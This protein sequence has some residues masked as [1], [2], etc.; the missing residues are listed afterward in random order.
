MTVDEGKEVLA[1]NDIA[2]DEQREHN[3]HRLLEAHYA[4]TGE[5]TEP[6]QSL[7]SEEVRQ[8]VGRR[9]EADRR[10]TIDDL[11]RPTDRDDGE[12]PEP[13][14]ALSGAT[15]HQVEGLKTKAMGHD[16]SWALQDSNL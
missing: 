1:A 4:V 14:L 9:A 10:A 7:L 2:G 8:Y 12:P 3:H 6:F 15:A 5:L 13:E 16:G 11:L